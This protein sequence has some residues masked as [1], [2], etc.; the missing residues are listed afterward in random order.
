MNK[1]VICFPLSDGRKPEQAQLWKGR[2]ISFREKGG[3][4]KGREVNH[5]TLQTEQAY[6]KDT[7]GDST[8]GRVVR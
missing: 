2:V 7:F 5:V 3:L 1:I 6:F 8:S 4:G